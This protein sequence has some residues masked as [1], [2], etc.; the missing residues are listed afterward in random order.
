M[1]NP[2][3]FKRGLITIKGTLRGQT[4]GGKS[5]AV[6][7]GEYN[8]SE[9]H[10]NDAW[11]VNVER[12]GQVYL[13]KNPRTYKGVHITLYDGRAWGHEKGKEGVRLGGKYRDSFYN[14]ES[15]RKPFHAKEMWYDHDNN[16][17]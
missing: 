3:L 2:N 16:N 10:T 13:N 15:E 8:Y 17:S 1:P 9:A 5:V 6:G 12:I 7:S 4:I 14:G 11:M